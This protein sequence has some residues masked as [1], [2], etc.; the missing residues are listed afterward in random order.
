MYGYGGANQDMSCTSCTVAGPCD[1][2]EPGIHFQFHADFNTIY[3]SS[4]SDYPTN[5]N[6]N[7]GYG[8]TACFKIQ[9]TFI[10]GMHD[11]FMILG[12]M[13]E[14]NGTD[15]LGWSV[16]WLHKLIRLLLAVCIPLIWI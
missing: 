6:V 10:D 4:G 9:D 7:Y 2:D 3:D 13:L 16:R 5:C 1:D 14:S 15:A 11:F 12:R 8:A